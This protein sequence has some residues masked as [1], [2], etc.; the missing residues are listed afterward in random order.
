MRKEKKET[1]GNLQHLR[2]F[3]IIQ[4]GKEIS[5]KYCIGGEHTLIPDKATYFVSRIAK[6]YGQIVSDVSVNVMDVSEVLLTGY[7]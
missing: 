7:C 1:S 2:Y 6:V 5:L 4:F 3:S